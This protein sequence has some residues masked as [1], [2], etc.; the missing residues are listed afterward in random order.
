MKS[1]SNSVA[2]KKNEQH[3]KKKKYIFIHIYIAT[4]YLF[5][6]CRSHMDGISVAYVVLSDISHPASF[7]LCEGVY[8]IFHSCHG[9]D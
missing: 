3:T 4:K 9:W 1:I 8:C 6:K 7:H 2:G 5:K